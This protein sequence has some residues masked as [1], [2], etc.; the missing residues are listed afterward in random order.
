MDIEDLAFVVDDHRE[1][2]ELLGV[3]DLHYDIRDIC[4]ITPDI[5][6]YLGFPYGTSLMRGNDGI[7][8]ETADEDEDPEETE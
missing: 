7:W 1:D 4:R 6:P 5:V 8:Y 2:I 3:L